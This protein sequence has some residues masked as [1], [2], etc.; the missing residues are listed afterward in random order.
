MQESNAR[1]ERGIEIA[2]KNH[3]RRIDEHTYK[4]KSQSSDK[5]YSVISSELG[6]NCSCPDHTLRK[7]C[8]KHIHAVEFSLKIRKQV[9]SVVI[10]Q[11]DTNCC[12]FAI[13]KT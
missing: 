13:L 1:K 6:W 8:C 3:L 7:I 9:E 12:N 11:I 4:V 5:E 2:N 10:N